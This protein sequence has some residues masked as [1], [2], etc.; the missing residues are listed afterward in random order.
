MFHT[1]TSLFLEAFPTSLRGI[2]SALSLMVLDIGMI[3]GAPMLGLIAEFHSYGALFTTIGAS[4]FAAGILYAISSIPVW[5]ARSRSSSAHP[6][7]NS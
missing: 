2:G 6:Q 3:G 1:G 7:P 4:C 5:R